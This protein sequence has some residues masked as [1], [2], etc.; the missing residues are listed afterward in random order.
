MT[1]DTE[2]GFEMDRRL[3]WQKLADG[4][5]DALCGAIRAVIAL[6]QAWAWWND[7]DPRDD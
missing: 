5:A 6:F 4:I 1:T 2:P 7:T 3:W